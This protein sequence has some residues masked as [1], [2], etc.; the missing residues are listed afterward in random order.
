MRRYIY[1]DSESLNS[2]LAQIEKGLHHSSKQEVHEEISHS[3]DKSMQSSIVGDIGAKLLGIGANIK[4]E[5]SSK[6]SQT[7]VSDEFIK[8]IEEKVLHD[9]V[10]DK[11]FRYIKDNN[12]IKT[13]KLT[14]GD[15]IISSDKMTLLDFD[16]FTR[17]F[18]E[19]GAMKF[20][21]E[22]EKEE[23][24]NLKR[25]IPKGSNMPLELRT[26]LNQID[27]KIREKE[28]ERKKYLHII[29]VIKNT[30][31]YKR[32]IMTGNYLIT[33][34][35]ACFR[36]NPEIFAFKYGGNITVVGFVTNIINN[37][38]QVYD[39]DFAVMYETVNSVML[40]LFRDKSEIYIVH[41]IAIYY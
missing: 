1:F 34:D 3:E 16:Y 13:E 7:D 21:V 15:F 22:N 29:D 35:D 12:L 25:Q 19:N 41:P 40:T 38:E 28:I 32:F 23:L 6:S 10:F 17:L 8:N 30:L 31:P 4:G 36:D 33:I 26:Q 9:Y 27:Q 14:M 18:S 2:Y 20:S 5:I 24:L 39:N 11:V 37:D